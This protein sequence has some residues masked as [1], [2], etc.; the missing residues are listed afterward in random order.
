MNRFFLFAACVAMC[1]S[2]KAGAQNQFPAVLAV[3][4]DYPPFTYR[5]NG[6]PQG[7]GVDVVR[8]LFDESGI[9]GA[10]AFMPWERAYLTALTQKNVLLFTLSR[11]PERE[12]LFQWIGPVFSVRVRLYKLK[13]RDDIRVNSL[14]DAHQYKIGAV[15]GYA[16][17]KLLIDDGFV[18]NKG[19]EE[20]PDE[21]INIHKFLGKRFDLICSNDFVLA[22]TLRSSGLSFSDVVPVLTL[23]KP[24]DEYMGFGMGTDK[25][26]VAAFS[27]AFARIKASGRYDKIIAG[28]VR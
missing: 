22:D 19:L 28:Y 3:T 15:R 11:T 5:V 18:V 6:V 7:M 2:G 4:D 17:E 25:K 10:I 23:N 9:N 26:T 20:A 27:R 16:S 14:A 21:E 12:S 1:L 13:S 8:A 24:F